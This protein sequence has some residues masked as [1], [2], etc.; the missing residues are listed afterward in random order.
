MGLLLGI[1]CLLLFGMCA[2]GEQANS[3]VIPQEIQALM[4][5]VNDMASF[6]RAMGLERVKLGHAHRVRPVSPG[7]P[8]VSQVDLEGHR[9]G[10]PGVNLPGKEG[11]KLL[12]SKPP[13]YQFGRTKVLSLGDASGPPVALEN[14]ACGASSHVVAVPQPA[15]SNGFYFPTHVRLHRCTGACSAKPRVLECA[16]TE[17]KNISLLV[18]SVSW[19]ADQS[20]SGSRPRWYRNPILVPMTNHTRCGCQCVIKPSQC[21]PQTQ[22]FSRENCRCECKP[23]TSPCPRHFQWDQIR[24][25]CV[26]NPYHIP[27]C[28]SRQEWHSDVCKCGCKRGGCKMKTKVRNPHTC[29]CVCPPNQPRCLSG[30]KRDRRDCEC[31]LRD[32]RHK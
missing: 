25:K 14:I 28:P 1:T 21:N 19:T 9:P 2:E 10:G 13:Q 6:L 12:G 17:T 18:F 24:C 26:C 23:Q 8:G 30:W 22:T 29:R 16:P 31:K 27:R 32:R 4:A 5:G 20:S 15:H 3:V 11:H 7:L